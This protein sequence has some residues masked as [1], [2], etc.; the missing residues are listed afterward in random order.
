MRLMRALDPDRDRE[1]KGKDKT[2]F[3]VISAAIISLLQRAADDWRA[4]RPSQF[5]ISG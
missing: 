3:I 5:V 4:G 1:K 2:V